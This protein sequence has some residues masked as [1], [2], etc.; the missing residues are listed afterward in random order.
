MRKALFLSFFVAAA[1]V[2]AQ[3]TRLAGPVSGLVFDSGS[4]SLR[5]IIGVPGSAY[6]GDAVLA[7][8][9]LAAAAPNSRAILAIMGGA[10]NVLRSSE[11]GSLSPSTIEGGMGDADRVVW[12]RTSS[13]AVI[14]NSGT[15]P[16]QLWRDQPGGVTALGSLAGR[17]LALAVSDNGSHVVA[18]IENEG[19]FVLTAGTEARRI[20]SLTRPNAIALSGEDLFIADGERQEIL[21]VTSFADGG[22]PELFVGAGQ[23]LEDPVGLAIS[24]DRSLLLV[25]SRASRSLAVLRSGTGEV[26][27]Q[28]PLDFEPSDIV[29]LTESLLWLNPRADSGAPLQV[30][31]GR[32][33]PT[34]WFVPM[35]RAD[36]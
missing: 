2:P 35:V 23:G 24:R 14:G 31:E 3:E 13:A 11:D 28:V 33:D 20:A 25:S 27:T 18:A 5:R 6:V 12:N 10:L 21:R 1:N 29:P 26:V 19:V 30:A 32:L 9:D 15:G 36:R 17:I 4:R 22:S 8:L 34:V 16:L 7:D